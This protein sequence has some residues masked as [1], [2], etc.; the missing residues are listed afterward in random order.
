M[1]TAQTV[2]AALRKLGGAGTAE[3]ADHLQAQTYQERGKVRQILAD[4]RK[5]GEVISNGFEGGWIYYLTDKPGARGA[6]Q[7]KLWKFACH[8]MQKG[9]SFTAA[10]AAGLAIC[11][12]DY[13]KR[14]YRWLWSA[15]YLA[16]AGRGRAGALLYRVVAA[17]E[18]EPAPPW[19]RRAEERKKKPEDPQAGTPAP[20][21]AALPAKKQ[22]ETALNEFGQAVVENAGDQIRAV[23]I[24]KKMTEVILGLGEHRHGEPTESHRK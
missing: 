4:L 21:E 8:R 23:E 22:L 13:A 18:H 16:I 15:G 19:N 17:K 2:K 12:R 6:V 11:D 24:I 7:K 14:Y 20:L 1:I 10:E 5:G 3:L 9:Q